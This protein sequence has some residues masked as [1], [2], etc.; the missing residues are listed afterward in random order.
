MN[1]IDHI[2]EISKKD[3]RFPT[4]ESRTFCV[5]DGYGCHPSCMVEVFN[6]KDT[7]SKVFDSTESIKFPSLFG[8]KVKEVACFKVPPLC[9]IRQIG[10]RQVISRD[11]VDLIELYYDRDYD[12]LEFDFILLGELDSLLTL[13][14]FEWNGQHGH[15]GRYRFSPSDQWVPFEERWVQFPQA[16]KEVFRENL[17]RVLRSRCF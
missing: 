13:N 9:D 10:K 4:P 8:H 16:L 17:I 12:R 11:G 5:V 1:H 14:D 2:D 3:A 15:G 7:I 6:V